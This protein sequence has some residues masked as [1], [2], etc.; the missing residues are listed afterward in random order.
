M[1]IKKKDIFAFLFFIIIWIIPITYTGIFN[2]DMP[3]FPRT[4]CHLQRIAIL[5]THSIESWP[6]FYIQVRSHENNQWQT[7]K[8]ED[9]FRLKPFGYRT[10]LFTILYFSKDSLGFQ[11]GIDLD[12][13]RREELAQWIAA[14]YARLYPHESDI[15]S[16]Q[17]VAAFYYTQEGKAI[18]GRWRKPRLE[19]FA[20][21]KTIVISRHDII[22]Q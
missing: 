4:L 12:A 20:K 15:E 8:E 21:D 2:C 14:R 10:R 17:F 6:I 7:L 18:Q 1:K 22:E 3:G 11:K 13:A 5:F 19:S 9:Y 16:V